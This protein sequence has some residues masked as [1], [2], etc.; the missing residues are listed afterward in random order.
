MEQLV[1]TASQT[2]GPFFAPCLLREGALRQV[3]VQPETEGQ[4]IRLEGR[5]LD[6]DGV[7]VPDAL[8]EIETR[9]NWGRFFR[10]YV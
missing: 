7:E 4:P 1:L 2:V 6:G 5:V 9:Q 10:T 8:V 3:L